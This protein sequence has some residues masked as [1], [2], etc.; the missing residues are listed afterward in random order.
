MHALLAD[1]WAVSDFFFFFPHGLCDC[2][3]YFFFLRVC[4]WLVERKICSCLGLDFELWFIPS[5]INWATAFSFWSL[6]LIVFKA[7]VLFG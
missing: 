3:W 6:V 7:V 5:S 4:V 2:L 1:I